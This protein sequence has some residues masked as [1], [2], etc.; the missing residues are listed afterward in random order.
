MRAI[1][2]LIGIILVAVIVVVVLGVTGAF[3][4]G[5]TP[6]PTP[7]PTPTPALTPTPTPAL[8]PTPAPTPTPTPTPTPAATP[9]PTPTPTFPPVDLAVTDV[10]PGDFRQG[11]RSWFS[12]SIENLGSDTYEDVYVFCHSVEKD[13]DTWSQ[14]TSRQSEAVTL[15]PGAIEEVA[16]LAVADVDQALGGYTLSYYV[17]YTSV[18]C[19]DCRTPDFL[20]N[21]NLLG[22]NEDVRVTAVSPTEVDQGD[23]GPLTFQIENQGTHHY[24]DVLVFCYSVEMD[25]ETWDEPAN[26]SSLKLALDPGGTGQVAM[27]FITDANQTPGDY[28]LSYELTFRDEEGRKFYTPVYHETLTV[29]GS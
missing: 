8:T 5:E 29:Q 11:E 13:G 2:I 16:A 24:G 12:F 25:G 19:T 28:V 22:P 26:R 7:T 14:P 21:V 6:A 3:E 23:A 15:A 20:H 9:L 18:N 10:S 27:E 1:P 4:G 17:H